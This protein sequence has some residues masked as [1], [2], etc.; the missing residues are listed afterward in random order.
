MAATF[1]IV[2]GALDAA[3]TAIREKGGKIDGKRPGQPWT[4]HMLLDAEAEGQQW[5]V[6]FRGEDRAKAGSDNTGYQPPLALSDDKAEP[7][8]IIL[9]LCDGE[10]AQAAAQAVVDGLRR[11]Y[12]MEGKAMGERYTAMLAALPKPKADPALYMQLLSGVQGI[13]L[14]LATVAQGGANSHACAKSHW[15]V[16]SI[17]DSKAAKAA[18]RK[19]ADAK[20]AIGLVVAAAKADPSKAAALLDGADDDALAAIQAV[21]EARKAAKAKAAAPDPKPARKGKKADEPVPA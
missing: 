16:G 1:S 17:A 9:G 18:A 14:A 2:P 13:A 4:R 19:T 20:S 7:R 10:G 15:R 8:R 3:V 11:F 5:A 12:G 6:V 21:I